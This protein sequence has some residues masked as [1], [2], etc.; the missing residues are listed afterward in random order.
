MGDHFTIKCYLDTQ[1][2]ILSLF[3]SKADKLLSIKLMFY[4]PTD[5]KYNYILVTKPTFKTIN[6]S[7]LDS[8]AILDKVCIFI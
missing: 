7:F 1:L 5:T 6:R 2:K 4:E 8:L 3:S